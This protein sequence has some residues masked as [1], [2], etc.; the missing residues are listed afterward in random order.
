MDYECLI[1]CETNG[2]LLYKVCNC[3][4]YIHVE[5][6][7]KMINVVSSHNTHCTVCKKKYSIKKKFIGCVFLNHEISYILAFYDILIIP[8]LVISFYGIYFFKDEKYANYTLVV[9]LIVIFI[10]TC[11]VTW[12]LFRYLYYTS[13][14]ELCYV[15]PVWKRS[16]LT[17]K[18]K[19]PKVVYYI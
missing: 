6:F 18:Y 1:C 16:A 13:K 15:K 11:L 4:S 5:C 14:K 19:N 7:E 2:K 17:F 9:S 12:I 3:N 10:C 8:I